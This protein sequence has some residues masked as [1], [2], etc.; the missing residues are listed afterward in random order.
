MY[1][2]ENATAKIHVEPLPSLLP[3]LLCYCVSLDEGV[4]ICYSK[5]GGDIHEV[6]IE[7]TLFMKLSPCAYSTSKEE[8]QAGPLCCTKA[9]DKEL[10]QNNLHSDCMVAGTMVTKIHIHCIDQC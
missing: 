6:G 2:L 5:W 9:Q 4:I 1:S 3:L 8:D 10:E 7:E